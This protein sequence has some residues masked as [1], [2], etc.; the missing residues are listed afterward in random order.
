VW[1]NK[2]AIAFMFACLGLSADGFETIVGER[3]LRLSGGEKQRVAFARAVLREPKVRAAHTGGI[4]DAV[5]VLPAHVTH[6]AT[7]TA[8]LATDSGLG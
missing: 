6:L 2:R 4:I 8:R 1:P 5:T 7:L 3:G